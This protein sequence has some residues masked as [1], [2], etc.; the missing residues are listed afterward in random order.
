MFTYELLDSRNN[1]EKYF[2]FIENVFI[3][4]IES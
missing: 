3:T 1:P 2:E 4:R